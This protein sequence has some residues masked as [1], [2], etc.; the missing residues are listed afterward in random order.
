MRKIAIIMLLFLLTSSFKLYQ[1]K[2]V[3]NDTLTLVT[4]K[5]VPLIKISDTPLTQEDVD[6]EK[7]LD[8]IECE[9]YFNKNQSIFKMVDKLEYDNDFSYQMASAFAS[10]TYYTDLI[11]KKKI[12]QN[13]DFGE[14]VNI[15]IPSKKY[16]WE[17][18]TETKIISGYK[19][20]KAVC[21]WEEFSKGRQKQLTFNSEVWFTPEIPAPFGPLGLDGL[22]G[23]VLEGNLG[24]GASHF[25]ATKISFNVNNPKI[26]LNLPTG[27]YITEDEFQDFQLKYFENQK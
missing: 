3:E 27:K 4:Y 1:T 17:I 10:G 23:L 18:T 21:V 8:K 9:L 15:I 19:C 11:S 26:K 25:Y 2:T 24:G 22:P 13:Q 12:N 6:F 7:A 5:I 14:T 16:K 20:Y